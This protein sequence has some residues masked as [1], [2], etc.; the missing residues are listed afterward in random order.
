MIDVS[1]SL[2]EKSLSS[3][4]GQN[5]IFYAHQLFPV[6]TDNEMKNLD[7]AREEK[8]KDPYKQIRKEHRLDIN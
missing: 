1:Q 5:A 3:G 7:N 4:I 8:L 6:L 2:A